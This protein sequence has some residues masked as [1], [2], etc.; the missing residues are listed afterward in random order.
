MALTKIL[1]INVQLMY[2][3]M[4]CSHLTIFIPFEKKTLS[5]ITPKNPQDRVKGTKSRLSSVNV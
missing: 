3:N 1:Y 4:Y 2:I 5:H